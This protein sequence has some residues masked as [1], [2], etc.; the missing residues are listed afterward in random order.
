MIAVTGASGKLG[1]ATL[2]FLSEKMNLS[3]VVA[4]VRDP[5]KV[6][7]YEQSGLKIRN[8]DYNDLKSL[9]EVIKRP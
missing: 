7:E 9:N 8:A 5:E 1:K 2:Q 3:K 4:I 6:V